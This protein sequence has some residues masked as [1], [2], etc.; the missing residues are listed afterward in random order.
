MPAPFRHE[1]IETGKARPLREFQV[2][3]AYHAPPPTVHTP[4]PCTFYTQTRLRQ[5]AVAK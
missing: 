1:A 2:G 5:T 4:Q 3:L